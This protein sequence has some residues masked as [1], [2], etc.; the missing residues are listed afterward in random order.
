M[1]KIFLVLFAALFLC[2]CMINRPPCRFNITI[3]YAKYLKEGVAVYP[4]APSETGH[5]EYTPIAKIYA[6]AGFGVEDN[7]RFFYPSYSD[8]V[9]Q[10][11][12]EAK[13]KG[14]NAI[15]S[16][17]ILETQDARNLFRGETIR[18]MEDEEI[19]LSQV[20]YV[21]SGFAATLKHF[22]DTDS[23]AIESE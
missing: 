16:V 13:K 6:F 7:G 2:S 23:P 17:R 9:D 3:D 20:Q 21:V 10:L 22:P 8:L 18:N 11:V 15:F 4:F 12:Q 1:K 5:V 19:S 14:A